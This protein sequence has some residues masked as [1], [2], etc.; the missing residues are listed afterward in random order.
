[1][2]ADPAGASAGTAPAGFQVNVISSA[3]A[4]E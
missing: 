3:R 2:K 1:M 4:A